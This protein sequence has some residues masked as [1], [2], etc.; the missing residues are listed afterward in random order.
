MP[1]RIDKTDSAVG[2]VRGTLLADIPQAD[3]NKIRGVS[4]NSAGKTIL[5]GGGT[6]GIVGVCIFDATNYRAGARCDIFKLGEIIVSGADLLT[7]GAL[8]TVNT[9][10]GVASTTVAGAS[11]IGVG[12]CVE[13]DRV[14]L[15]GRG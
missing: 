2:V 14:V 6:T 4:I 1:A 3:W 5:G 13:N 12:Y 9:T 7:A 10:T 8:I 15:Q 11:Q